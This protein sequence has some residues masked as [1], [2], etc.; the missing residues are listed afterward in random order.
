M[1]EEHFGP[2]PF[3]DPLACSAGPEACNQHTARLQ[4]GRDFVDQRS[5]LSGREMRH[6]IEGAH[7]V[8]RIH[9]KWRLAHI[10]FYKPRLGDIPPSPGNL[11]RRAIDA[12]DDMP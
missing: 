2:K 5:L 10:G 6:R 4:P 8:K 12:N 7:G 3:T 1:T 11:L 9:F